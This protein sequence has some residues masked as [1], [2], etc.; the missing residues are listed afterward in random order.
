MKVVCTPL[1]NLFKLSTR[2][3]P[4]TKEEVEDI[5]KVPYASAVGCLMYVMVYTRSDLAHAISVVSKYVANP[6]RQ[7]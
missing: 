1:T 6:G 7:H 2:Q 5:S 3:C 4:S